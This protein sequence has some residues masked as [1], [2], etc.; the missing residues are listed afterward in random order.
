MPRIFI[1]S[2]V[3]SALAIGSGVAGAQ[4]LQPPR[5]TAGGLFGGQDYDPNSPQQLSLTFDMFGG[6][7]DYAE[8]QADPSV[9][10]FDSSG[11]VSRASA[12]LNYRRGRTERFFGASSD[13]P[14][15]A[16]A[17]IR[18]RGGRIFFMRRR[19]RRRGVCG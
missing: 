11:Y 6:Y 4:G 8:P 19:G 3:L 17:A 5:A 7:D 2:V 12:G 18:R 15:N 1:A 13:M 9:P 16:S 10:T 14:I